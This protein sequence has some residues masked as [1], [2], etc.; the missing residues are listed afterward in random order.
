MPHASPKP[1]MTEFS[2]ERC[3][4]A[5]E[6]A[7]GATAVTGGGEIRLVKPGVA[8]AGRDGRAAALAA[9]GERNPSLTWRSGIVFVESAHSVLAT[10]GCSNEFRCACENGLKANRF[11]HESLL[12][13]CGRNTLA[14]PPSSKASRV[15]AAIRQACQSVRCHAA[16]GKNRWSS[17]PSTASKLISSARMPVNCNQMV[18]GEVMRF[19]AFRR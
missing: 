10:R 1:I 11:R 2:R 5:I 3:F 18:S 13:D 19:C 12:I 15:I 7:R 14:I 9:A 16:E 17:A 6:L 4:V 8:D